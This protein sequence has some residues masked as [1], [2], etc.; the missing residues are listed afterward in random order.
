MKRRRR[1][2]RFQRQ[3]TG[4]RAPSSRCITVQEGEKETKRPSRSRSKS[5]KG[6][7]EETEEW[8]RQVGNIVHSLLEDGT[9]GGEFLERGRQRLHVLG[10]EK[11]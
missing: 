2:V 3:Y 1:R 6:E 7:W 5:V 9:K 8:G 11:P 10:E 4:K